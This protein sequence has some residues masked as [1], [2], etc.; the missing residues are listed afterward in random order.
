MSKRENI[1][2]ILSGVNEKVHNV[3]EKS[4]FYNLLGEDNI[5]KNINEAL[6]KAEKIVSK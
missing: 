4:G 1:H 2:I 3:L 5:C 6:E